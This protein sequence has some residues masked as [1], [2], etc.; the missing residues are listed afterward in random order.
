MGASDL[1]N[2]GVAIPKSTVDINHENH[3]PYTSLR[4]IR[5]LDSPTDDNLLLACAHILIRLACKLNSGISVKSNEHTNK[6]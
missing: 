6:N 3:I 2:D 4:T 1:I 5:L